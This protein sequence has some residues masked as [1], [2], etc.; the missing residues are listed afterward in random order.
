MRLSPPLR[1]QADRDALR[2]ALADGT[3]DALVSDHNPVADDAKNLPF[4]EAEPGASAVELL[5]SLAL[6]WG[7]DSGVDLRAHAGAR[8]LRS[9]ARARR[10]P[11]HAG[12]QRRSAGRRRRRRRLRVRSG[13]HWQVTRHTLTSQGKHTPFDFA[14]T[15]TALPGRVRATR[16]RR[17]RVVRGPR[18]RRVHRASDE[19]RSGRGGWSRPVRALVG[20]W[21]LVRVALHRAA[22]AWPS[23]RCVFALAR[24]ARP[25]A[26]HRL[27]VARPA[28]ARS[29]CGWSPRAVPPRGHAAGRQPRLVARHRGD[30]RGR[31]RTRAS[32]PSPTCKRWPLLGWLIGA[33]G[34]LF[35]ER[36]R[37]RDALRVVHQMAA[38]AGRRR[39]RS[40]C[41]PRAPPATAA[42]CC[43]STPT[44]CRPRSPPR[45][46][47]AGGAALYRA[48]ALAGARRSS[49]LGATTLVHSVWAIACARGVQVRVT[50]CRRGHGARRRPARRWLHDAAQATYRSAPA[51]C[52]AGRCAAT[53]A[54]GA[55]GVAAQALPCL[56]TAAAAFAAA[57]ASPR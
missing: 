7:Q 17:R 45:A 22:W 3:I 48:A 47:A 20:A 23:S 29:V 27:V 8:D 24:R 2:A 38:G 56:A 14:A 34:T 46:G 32:S 43:R 42:R 53:P 5:L 19:R 44:C 30:A 54:A 1:Q 52:S 49:S 10:G 15:G 11:R 21:R 50:C 25:P 51:L 31:A 6:K 57:S 37:K 28:A 39:H 33:V 4:A 40:R 35:I 41:S 16:A 9:G 12:R 36:E 55:V 26:A 18:A 13:A